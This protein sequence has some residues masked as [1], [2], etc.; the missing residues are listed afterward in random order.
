MG[1]LT[2]TDQKLTHALTR[3]LGSMEQ[4]TRVAAVISSEMMRTHSYSAQKVAET[5]TTAQD[6]IAQ[7][8]TVSPVR[9]TMIQY[10]TREYLSDMLQITDGAANSI[11]Y[12]LTELT[13]R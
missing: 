2:R 11:V 5:L 1:A 8:D 3:S 9:W 13:M 4:A 12:Q 6:M 10:T 7:A